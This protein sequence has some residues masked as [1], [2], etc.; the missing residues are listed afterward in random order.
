[1][2]RLHTLQY[3]TSGQAA[4]GLALY[5]LYVGGGASPGPTAGSTSEPSHPD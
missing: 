5:R 4:P 3:A 1:M 2:K